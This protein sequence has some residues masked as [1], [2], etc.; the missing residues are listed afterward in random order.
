MA[1]FGKKP[2]AGKPAGADAEPEEPAPEAEEEAGEEAPPA[3]VR[4][5]PPPK[6]VD[7]KIPPLGW[8][9]IAVS[10]ILM[11]VALV[12]VVSLLDTAGSTEVP[13]IIA[14]VLGVGGM[15]GVGFALSKWGNL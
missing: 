2:K 11:V 10:V 12:M 1:L 13:M 3:P 6:P 5:G 7:E 4:R 9:M 14:A 15:I 8:V